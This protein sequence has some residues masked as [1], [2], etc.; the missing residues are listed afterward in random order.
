MCTLLNNVIGLLSQID[1][2]ESINTISC[3]ATAIVAILALQN[4]KR[5]DKAKRE[6][7]FLD[8]L[9]EAAHTYITDISSA[10]TVFDFIKIG[11]KAH[12]PTW[13]EGTQSDLA[14]LGVIAY[15]NK[16]GEQAGERLGK[17]LEAAQPS[18]IRLRSLVSK[19]QVFRLKRYNVCHES[20]AE[21]TQPFEQMEA[22]MA[23]IMLGG[24]NWEHPDIL[25]MLDNTIATEA[26]MMRQKLMASNVRLIEFSQSAYLELYG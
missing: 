12:I 17:A 2:H 20:V 9:V 21:L 24:W 15:A 14:R 8:A 1:W 7:E 3:A 22:I 23:F 6:A 25:R 13:D 10:V 4:W 19:G 18:M 16:A 11:M 26:L 5:Q